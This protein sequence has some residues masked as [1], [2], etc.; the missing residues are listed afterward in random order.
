MRKMNRHAGY[1][2][3][4]FIVSRTALFASIPF[5]VIFF[6][7]VAVSI[8]LSSQAEIERQIILTKTLTSETQVNLNAASKILE[9]SAFYIEQ[10]SLY[11]DTKRNELSQYLSTVLQKNPSFSAIWVTDAESG[12]VSFALPAVPTAA[13]FD[14]SHT[15]MYKD[16][17]DPVASMVPQVIWSNIGLNPF[18]SGV[19]VSASIKIRD[20]ILSAWFNPTSLI[21]IIATQDWEHRQFAF[22]CDSEGRLISHPDFSVVQ[23]RES[24]LGIPAVKAA[25]RGVPSYSFSQFKATDN[26]EYLYTIIPEPKT[27]WL[28]GVA[29]ARRDLF[30]YFYWFIIGGILSFAI[31]ASLIVL[32]ANS[33]AKRVGSALSSLIEG[34]RSIASG[35]YGTVLDPQHF[36][37]FIAISDTI[38]SVQTAVQDREKKLQELNQNLESKVQI[39][40]E[41][42]KES[43]MELQAAL[44][45]LSA[46][47]DKMVK[48]EKLSAL[49]QLAAGIA[50]EL[51][52]PLG[53]TISAESVLAQFFKRDLY[54]LFQYATSLSEE[55]R[56]TFFR[57]FEEGISRIDSTSTI[58]ERK[59]RK[60]LQNKLKDLGISGSFR[61]T[62]YLINA[63]FMDYPEEHPEFFDLPNYEEILKNLNGLIIPMRMTSLIAEAAQKSVRVVQALQNYLRQDSEDAFINISVEEGIESVLTLLHNKLKH[64]I[65]IER[66][67]CGVSVY[68]VSHQLSQVWMNLLNNAAHAM[69]YKGTIKIVTR[70]EGEKAV[71]MFYDNGHGIPEEI[72][73]NIFEPFFTTKKSEGMGLGLDICKR[74]IEN[75]RGSIEVKSKP[76]ETVFIITLP[77]SSQP[78]S[79]EARQYE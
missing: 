65:N 26:E 25:S 15:S 41:E 53:A 10:A 76:G 8:Y 77:I 72:R 42:L 37:E 49:G 66:D 67:F 40:T 57:L 34:T 7:A 59:E 22:V 23:Q 60:E 33:A 13:G 2:L 61:I 6:S 28:V 71:I 78:E 36:H 55:S 43:N 19:Y 14:I 21:G 32:G 46:T 12:I 45:E 1:K 58:I 16:V 18:Y 17:T 11:P 47:Q 3:K 62:D 4:N 79:Q 63:G 50:H 75:H 73:K 24:M 39:R 38:R 44:K 68:A 29:H 5:A 69:D 74:I 54:T 64:G 70:K 35:N 31:A 9:T 52:T 56:N 27:G 20:N 48:T 51:N 30:G